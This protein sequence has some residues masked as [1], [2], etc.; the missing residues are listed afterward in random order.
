MQM[1]IQAGRVS[2]IY[3]TVFIP[4]HDFVSRRCWRFDLHPVHLGGSSVIV[5][6]LCAILD[7]IRMGAGASA[8]N[9]ADAM[10]RGASKEDVIK[11]FEEHPGGKRTSREWFFAAIDEDVT[12][13]AMSFCKPGDAKCFPP[14]VAC[15]MVTVSAGEDGKP[16]ANALTGCGGIRQG[17][18]EANKCLNNDL[19]HLGSDGKAMTA[20]LCAILV[21]KG[22]ISWDFTVKD[23]ED[24]LT[25][26]TDSKYFPVTLKQLLSHTGGFDGGGGSAWDLA[27]EEHNANAHNPR[28]QRHVCLSSLLKSPPV[29]EPGTVHVYSNW[30]Y[31]MAGHMLEHKLD[32]SFEDLLYIHLLGPL[33]ISKFGFGMPVGENNPWGHGEQSGWEPKDPAH[34]GSDN[35]TAITPA[36]RMH[37]GLDDWAR[38]AA[39]TLSAKLANEVLGL[40]EETYN[41]MYKP[42][43]SDYSTAGWIVVQRPWA[44][45]NAL[46]HTGSNTLNSC[47][48]WLVPGGFSREDTPLGNA[49]V[50]FLVCTNSGN[51]DLLDQIVSPMIMKA[52]EAE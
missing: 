6:L 24:V 31:T 14:G 12:A 10:E 8:T 2:L 25:N 49:S 38:F 35:P 39:V 11:Y 42:V 41:D 21:D 4:I 3:S 29:A 23:C 30:G 16:V 20:M 15:A 7:H 19:W 17:N 45:G 46:T 22:M 1:I 27:W 26:E 5:S 44:K 37:M 9:V 40:T 51:S 18:N 48:G 34:A 52:Q 33:G 36:G 50:G 13:H 47:I 43:A 32:K 28:E